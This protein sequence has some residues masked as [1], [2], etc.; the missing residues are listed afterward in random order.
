MKR[1]HKWAIVAL[2]LLALAGLLGGGIY[3]IA[4]V[5]EALWTKAVTDIL[6]VTAQG[7]H[8]LDTYMEKDAETLHLLAA[9][10][11][12]EDPADGAT[13]LKK[14]RLFSE[15]GTS[16]ICVVLDT[17]TVY[18]DR[19][20]TGY[21][22]SQEQL[23]TFLAL[24]ESG[25]RRPFLDGY[26]GVWT[27][28]NYE[29][30]T[31]ADGTVGLVQKT[32]PLAEVAQRFSLSFYDDTGFSYVVDREGDILIRSLHKNSNR[33]FQNL[34]D[35]VDLQGNESGAV[36]TFRAAL[37]NGKKG[38]ARF[39]YQ[40]QEYVFCYVP[41]ESV[42]GW[43]VISIVPNQVIMEQAGEIIE[44]S[45][46]LL[47]L[48]AA[49]V[50]VLTAF[51]LFYRYSTRRIVA[52]K[53]EARR[54]AE[55]A[56]VAKSRFLSN[57]SHDIRTP[58]NAIIGMTKL[59]ADQADQPDKVRQYLKNID[60]SGRM[61]VGLINDIL[62]MSRIESGKMVLSE[63]DTSLEE[64]L[65]G[66]VKMV[67]PMVT[68]KK[69]QFEVRLL[70][71]QHETLC[72]DA[73]RLN[74]VLINLLSN[75]VKF[76]PAGGAI[77]VEVA[78][79]PAVK[80]GRARLIFRVA[81]TGIGMKA[82]FREHLFDTFSREQDSRVDKIEGSG[83]GMAIT[84]MIVDLMGGE[85]TVQSQPDRGSTFTVELDMR[86][87]GRQLPAEDPLPPMRVLLADDDAATRQSA[88]AFLRELGAAADIADSGQAAVEI[89]VAAHGRKADYDLIIL[90]WKMAGLSG[91]EAVCGIRER[92]PAEVPVVIFSAYDWAQIEAEAV[93][94]GANGFIQKPIFRSTLYHCLRQYVLRQEPSAPVGGDTADLSGRRILLAEDNAFNQEIARE[95]LQEVGAQVETVDDGRACVERFA[96]MPA[97][98]FDLILMDIHMP[99][100][101]G[102][103][104]ARQIRRMRRADAATIPIFAMTADAFAEDIEAAKA[105]GMNCHI[106]KPLDIPVML[107][108]MQ[109][110]LPR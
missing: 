31:F 36:E 49:G 79:Q 99:V 2:V 51:F 57:M 54:A 25:V 60:L 73:L 103:E 8:A 76:T 77:T 71:V 30:F 12:G 53:E 72:F 102:H 46:I 39:Q 98:Y 90:D 85:I 80:E 93:A 92:I 47:L 84:K 58:M 48:V 52:A 55:S 109:R 22:L 6:E 24:A 87:P 10:L 5:Q 34:F 94:A 26:T 3:Y 86:L 63:T 65:T 27:L 91:I 35:I 45:Q 28:G 43:D 15:S 75:A 67:Q 89:A 7:R 82:D 104:A 50:L 17:G 96:Q 21:V 101:D 23:D 97:G 62:D 64:L 61:L 106:A 100:M 81:D 16:Y 56:S 18:T 33:T 70:Q 4:H 11:S 68:E 19:Q 66:I 95:I 40:E 20:Q 1:R 74:Q 14:V 44:Q 110:Y 59:A 32:R 37:G 105:A 69:Q 13:L 38:V 108:E 83:L 107:R 29:R 78:E 88:A 9:D 41:L 42:P